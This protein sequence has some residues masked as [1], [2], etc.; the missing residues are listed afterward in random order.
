VLV[1][2]KGHAPNVHILFETSSDKYAW[3][4]SAVA[5]AT[6]GQTA[7]GVSIDVWQVSFLTLSLSLCLCGLGSVG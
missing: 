7:R 3:L 2:E 4:N 1:F 5:Y 6:G